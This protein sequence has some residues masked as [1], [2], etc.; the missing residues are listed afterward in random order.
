M[1]TLPSPS[2]VASIVALDGDPILRNLRITWG[3]HSLS[4]GMRDLTGRGDINW[5]T[6]GTWASK[7]AGRFIRSDE[8]PGVFKKLLQDSGPFAEAEHLLGVDGL[9]HL[10]GKI[11]R[12]VS[13]YIMV[14]NRVVF[15]EL[16]GVFADY[17]A[18]FDGACGPDPERLAR[19]QARLTPGMPEPDR[20]TMSADGTIT[21]EAR[22]GQGLLRDMIADYHHARFETDAKR[23]AELVLRANARGGLHEQTRL[24]TYIAGSL[25]API[26]DVLM[27]HAH[28]QIDA[29]HSGAA[30][31]AKH[32]LVDSILPAICRRL[33]KAW[34]DFSTLSLMEL[35]L[36]DAVLH[37]SRPLPAEKGRPIYP[38]ILATIDD[39]TLRGI[40]ADYGALDIATAKESVIDRVEDRFASLLGLGH[41]K[42]PAMV[43]AGAIDW[44]DL[45]QRMKYIFALFR[46]RADD[47]HLVSQPF[48]FLQREL[49]DGGH[50][51][52]GPL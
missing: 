18:E 14:G 42:H 52:P 33:E 1:R 17:L 45:R 39:P 41:P 34:E 30:A 27:P 32:A 6:L 50:V 12:D 20:A 10:A 5:C 21:A 47:L 46:S 37:L 7:T 19:F 36:P 51:P 2:D 29:K 3:Y 49:I 4:E 24:Q 25:D 22:G 28:A 9:A 8:L 44:V 31:A 15:A 40:L 48:T 43:D 16:G 38:E 23:R 13:D 26:E 35:T 11:V